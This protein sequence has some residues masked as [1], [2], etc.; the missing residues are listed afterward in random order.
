MDIEEINGI[1]YINDFK[2]D[3]FTEEGKYRIKLFLQK[4]LKEL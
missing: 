1:I 2:I 4:V 3:D